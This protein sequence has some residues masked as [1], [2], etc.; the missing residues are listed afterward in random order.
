LQ[1]LGDSVEIVVLIDALSPVVWARWPEPEDSEML[2]SFA[3]D[4]TRLR[5]LEIPD[6][7]L[8]GLGT[9]EALA[10]FLD[11]GR[12]AGLLPATVEPADLRRLFERFRANRLALAGYG[13]DSIP[14]GG[15]VLLFRAAEGVGA[16]AEEDPTLGWGGLV[17]GS[18]E[19][20]E[21]PG[22]HYSILGDGVETLAGR[23]RARL[24]R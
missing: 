18:L 8:S 5:G 6:V 21:L 23:L 9:D 14:Y 22:D 24:D 13:A 16:V 10:L 4:L 1:T 11:L 7:D 17:A 20:D 19:V 3:A 2:A 12:R 15:D